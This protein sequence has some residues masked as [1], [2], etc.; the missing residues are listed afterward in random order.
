MLSLPPSVRIFVATEPTDMRKSFDGLANQTRSVMEHDPLS[1]HLF[2]FFNRRRIVVKVL[3]WDRNGYCVIAKRLERGSFALAQANERGVMEL[4]AAEL[5]L[6][7][8]GIDL[9]G[10]QRRGRWQRR[11]ESSQAAVQGQL[12]R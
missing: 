3:Y 11:Q 4:E 8:E 5:G 6:I 1:G 9:R 2:V 10:A 12:P 7:M